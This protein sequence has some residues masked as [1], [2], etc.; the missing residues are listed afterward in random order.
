MGSE[1]LV[2]VAAFGG[3]SLLVFLRAGLG[4]AVIATRPGAEPTT[5]W[6]RNDAAA[7]GGPWLIG[8][9]RI[10]SGATAWLAF[11]GLSA[12]TSLL[13]ASSPDLR[14]WSAE[15]PSSLRQP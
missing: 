3:G 7:D 15:G 14:T 12:P 6:T 2:Q 1:D 11:G 9:Y 8:V 13:I 10:R 5:V 4:A